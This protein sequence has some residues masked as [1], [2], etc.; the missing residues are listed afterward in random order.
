M[1]F[2]GGPAEGIESPPVG[3]VSHRV[4]DGVLQDVVDLADKHL[5]GPALLLR[6]GYHSSRLPARIS[7]KAMG[8][9][10]IPMN[11]VTVQSEERP[12]FKG[13]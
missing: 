3:Q 12:R 4:A 10:S 7:A 8:T 2:Q 6:R 1:P 9:K 5:E 13:L 11:R